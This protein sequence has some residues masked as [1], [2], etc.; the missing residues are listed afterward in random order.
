[1]G[2]VTLTAT[3]TARGSNVANLPLNTT[4]TLIKQLQAA[5]SMA[6]SPA[7]GTF[8]G[9]VTLTATLTVGGSGVN[10]KTI[11]FT[12][13]GNSVGSATTNSSGIAT[14]NNVS[15][16][17][18]N[19]GTYTG[20]IV[21]TFTADGSGYLGSSGNATLTVSKASSTTTVTVSDAVYDG[22]PHG[23]TANVTG[24]G[25]LSQSLTVSYSGRNGTT[26]G[27][28]TIPP[29]SAGDYTASAS[30]AEDANHN[31][32]NDSKNYSITKKSATW[33]TND[34]SKTYGAADPNP[35]TTGSGSGFV[36]GDN[37]TA[38]LP[39]PPVKA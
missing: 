10:G 28:S 7:A 18:I 19:T 3:V 17:G 27:P 30:Y 8:G 35:L 16:S 21:A 25:G 39:A 26:Y 6:V 11:A 23:G 13:N 29:T 24:A 15:L 22:G 37:V 31:S 2:S 38:T 4:T 34:A 5:T 14:L 9:T 12:L 33:T 32:S 1:M 20:G 36:A